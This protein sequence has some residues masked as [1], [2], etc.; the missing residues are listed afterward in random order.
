MPLFHSFIF[1]PAFPLLR[2]LGAA[3]LW[4]LTISVNSNLWQFQSIAPY[5]NGIK[6]GR[7]CS[8]TI[9]HWTIYGAL[10]LGCSQ[11][12]EP[13][14]SF[15]GHSDHV[16]DHCNGELLIRRS[17]S[18][19]RALQISHLRVLSQSVTPWILGKNPLSTACTRDSTLQSFP[20]N[21][22]HRWEWKQR[23]I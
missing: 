10:S 23:P 15:L 18:T 1:I 21:H 19:F 5:E 14:H 9:R 3:V 20:K 4:G 7:R 22:G 6:Q 17:V 13:Y 16:K 8:H 2:V 12:D 11:Q